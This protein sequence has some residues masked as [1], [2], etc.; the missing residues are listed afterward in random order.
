VQR[1]FAAI[2]I[3]A[4]QAHEMQTLKSADGKCCQNGRFGG[5][6]AGSK[7]LTL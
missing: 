3:A 6:A 5:F 2:V 7:D 4:G 1:F